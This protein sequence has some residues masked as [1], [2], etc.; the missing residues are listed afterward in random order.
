MIRH[1]FCLLNGFS[2]FEQFNVDM[3]GF[4]GEEGQIRGACSQ[5][6]KAI[7]TASQL[8][9]S[10]FKSFHPMIFSFS[11]VFPTLYDMNFAYP[12]LKTQ[13]M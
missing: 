3:R 12:I 4:R 9:K 10:L 13:H 7:I 8:A 1:E 5:V 6:I 2:F 11:S